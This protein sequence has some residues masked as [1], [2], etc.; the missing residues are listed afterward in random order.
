MSQENGKDYFEGSNKYLANPFVDII[1][2][3][4]CIIYNYWYYLHG[5]THPYNSGFLTQ[6]HVSRNVNIGQNRK[7]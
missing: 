7:Q 1:I 5:T 2:I 3:I 6:Q 4:I